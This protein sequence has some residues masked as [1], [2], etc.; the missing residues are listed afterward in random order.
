MERLWFL[1]MLML[2]LVEMSVEVGIVRARTEL[3]SPPRAVTHTKTGPGSLILFE[4]EPLKKKTN[5]ALV[6]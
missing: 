6:R 4:K 5:P 2:F 3:D 1:V